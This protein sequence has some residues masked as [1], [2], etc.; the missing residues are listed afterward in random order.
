MNNT[1]L[2][3]YTQVQLKGV[4]IKPDEE[5]PFV[6]L[7][8]PAGDRGFSVEIGPFEASSIILHLEGVQPSRPMTHDLL[9]EV[10]A[11]NKMKVEGLFIYEAHDNKYYSRLRYRQGLKSATLEVRPS[12]G[13]ALA[14]RLNFPIYSHAKLLNPIDKTLTAANDHLVRPPAFRY[15]VT[16]PPAHS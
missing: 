1:R 5:A 2:H 4:A 14:L 9:A 13:L 6:L 3:D 15:E 16:Q 10:F 12:D 8:T 7:R 11:L